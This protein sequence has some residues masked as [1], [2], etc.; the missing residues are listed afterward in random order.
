LWA[1]VVT[2]YEEAFNRDAQCGL[3]SQQADEGIGLT[4]RLPHSVLFAAA[5]SP[6]PGGEGKLAPSRSVRI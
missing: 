2:A 1:H 4:R 6:Y 5:E 3:H